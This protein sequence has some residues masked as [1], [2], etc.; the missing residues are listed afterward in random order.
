[1]IGN[2][3]EGEDSERSAGF[4][5][6]IEEGLEGVGVEAAGLEAGTKVPSQPPP[7]HILVHRPSP[8]HPSRSTSRHH[9]HHH[10]RQTLAIESIGLHLE[11]PLRLSDRVG[12]EG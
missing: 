1:M 8:A 11:V 12:L 2:E 9:H 6:G 4:G 10:H 3:G 7:R 5:L